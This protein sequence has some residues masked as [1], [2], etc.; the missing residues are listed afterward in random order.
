[1]V[2][3]WWPRFKLFNLGEV[4]EF[5]HVC[6]TWK[7]GHLIWWIWCCNVWWHTMTSQGSTNPRKYWRETIWVKSCSDKNYMIV[8]MMNIIGSKQN[9]RVTRLRIEYF[10]HGNAWSIQNKVQAYNYEW[11]S[12]SLDRKEKWKTFIA[13]L[14][15]ILTRYMS[16]AA[17]LHNRAPW[18]RMLRIRYLNT[19]I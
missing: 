13:M 9:E 1:M 17:S 18:T 6:A 10:D 2:W 11:G 19:V 12:Q 7:L 8:E 5:S 15:A 4:Q 14:Q 16:S 3:N